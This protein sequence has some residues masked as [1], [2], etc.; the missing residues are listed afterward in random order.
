MTANVIVPLDGS[1]MAERALVCGRVLAAKLDG[2]LVAMSSVSGDHGYDDR[3]RYLDRLDL[4]ENG[5][6]VVRARLQPAKAIDTIARRW[7]PSIVCMSARGRSARAAAVLGSTTAEVL[8]QG[9]ASVIVVGPEVDWSTTTRCQSLCVCLEDDNGSGPAAEAASRLADQLDVGVRYATVAI[10]P[11]HADEARARIA[12]RLGSRI[13]PD[14]IEVRVAPD[15]AS[16]LLALA[17]EDPGLVLALATRGR[18]RTGKFVAGSTTLAVI[19]RSRC[20]V[21]AVPPSRA[22]RSWRDW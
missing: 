4:P 21:L 11:E 7:T 22:A 19:K 13:D 20:P 12:A 16:G 17:N 1:E 5:H 8:A 10:S 6:R 2:S 9:A 3:V 18:T 14:R 15:T